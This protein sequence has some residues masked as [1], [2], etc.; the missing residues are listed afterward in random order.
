VDRDYPAGEQADVAISVSISIGGITMVNHR[1]LACQVFTIG[2]YAK[3][4]RLLPNLPPIIE[5]VL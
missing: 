3:A 5:C 1:V 2:G 4:Q